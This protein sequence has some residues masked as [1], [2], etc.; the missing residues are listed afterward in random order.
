MA[1]CQSICIKGRGGGNVDKILASI[2]RFTFVVDRDEMGLYFLC[3]CVLYGRV[4]CFAKTV[5]VFPEEDK[6]THGEAQY[7][8]GT[9]SNV[10]KWFQGCGHLCHLI[11]RFHIPALAFIVRGSP[12]LF[13]NRKR[14]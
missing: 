9:V 3:F 4:L 7:P 11:F 5:L 12:D 8:C 2:Y 13:S 14:L 6:G 10:G 1:F